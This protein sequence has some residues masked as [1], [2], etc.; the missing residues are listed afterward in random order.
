MDTKPDGDLVTPRLGQWISQL[1]ISSIAGD[2][3]SHLKLCLLDS[4]GCGL[5][6]AI[7][8][9]GRITGD[10][11]ATFSPGGMASLFARVEKVSPAD[12]A[13]ANGTAIHGFEIDDAHIT[14]SLHPGAVTLPA[15]LAVAEAR[16]ASGADL[17]TALATGYEVGLRVGI[18]AG[19]SHSTS[20]YHVTGTAGALGA[21]AAAARLLKLSPLRAAHALGIGA[22]Q[23]AGLYAARTGGMAKRFHAGRASQSG[24]VAAYLAER[25]FTGTL[26][27]LEA[28]FGGFMS[29]LRGQHD[30][31]T[32]LADLG[33]R[34]ETARVGL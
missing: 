1:T 33:E 30:P 25:G 18:C 7:Q 10:V 26:D 31:T 21:A 4:I 16:Q 32:M 14:S 19:V 29:T 24:V 9:C 3:L 2:I 12:A 11:A 5:F 15:S 27:A 8:R 22:T 34:W 17:L 13:L 20:G 28:S 23:A 6:G